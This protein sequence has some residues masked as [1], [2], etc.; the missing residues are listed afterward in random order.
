MAKEESK[1]PIPLITSKQ[2]IKRARSNDSLVITEQ[3]AD[4]NK[5]VI[6]SA[7]APSEVVQTLAFTKLQPESHMSK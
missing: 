4:E 6:E 2:G 7:P 3:P 1:E 5:I